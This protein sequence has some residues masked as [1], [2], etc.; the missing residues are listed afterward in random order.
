MTG[1]VYRVRLFEPAPWRQQASCRGLDPE[2]FFPERGAPSQRAK[3]VCA[4]CP[5]REPCRDFAIENG[6][7]FGI[8]GALSERQRRAVRRQRAIDVEAA[9]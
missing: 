3:A 6:E 1:P 2:L 9:S 5:V 4:T 8:W 7:K